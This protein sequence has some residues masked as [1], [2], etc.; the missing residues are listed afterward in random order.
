MTF[1]VGM[2]GWPIVI[3]A[4]VGIWRTIVDGMRDRASLAVLAWAVACTVFLAVAVMRVDAPFQRYAAEFF[5][6]VLL[7][8]CPAAVMLAARGASWGWSAGTSTRIASAGLMLCSGV[9]A[10]RSWLVWFA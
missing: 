4:L 8:T 2:I 3:L 9:L 7:A 6:R 1:A 10:V 5:G